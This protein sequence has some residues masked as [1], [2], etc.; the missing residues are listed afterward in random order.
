MGQIQ[1]SH[2]YYDTPSKLTHKHG[3]TSLLPVSTLSAFGYRFIEEADRTPFH[4]SMATSLVNGVYTT[5]L[6]AEIT[7]SSLV[8]CWFLS[9]RLIDFSEQ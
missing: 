5:L 8:P 4:V 6:I 3:H 9:M 1:V 2:T 7:R